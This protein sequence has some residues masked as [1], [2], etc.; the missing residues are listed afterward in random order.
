MHMVT[1]YDLR[2]RSGRN[3]RIV[4][5]FGAWPHRVLRARGWTRPAAVRCATDG[6]SE[7]IEQS[8]RHLAMAYDSLDDLMADERQILP[9]KIADRIEA[10]LARH[11]GEV[12]GASR[13]AGE[14]SSAEGATSTV[15]LCGDGKD[16]E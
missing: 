5:Q 9:P 6:E 13:L 1:Y 7:W 2:Q 12:R 3:A 4:V 16:S 15:V 14:A 11:N 10:D 8:M